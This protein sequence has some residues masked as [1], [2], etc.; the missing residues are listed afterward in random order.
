MA[1]ALAVSEASTEYYVGRK[2]T[3]ADYKSWELKPGE[4]F[5]LIHG[6]AY[7][8]SAPT[9]SHQRISMLLSGEFYAF[10]KDK[11]CEAFAAPVDVRL[12]YE[13]DGSDD[14][15]VQPDLVVVCDP[16]KLGEEGVRGA[17]DVAVEIL[18]PSNTAVEMERKQKSVQSAALPGLAIP[19]SAVF[20]V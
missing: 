9:I 5:E 15:V 2:Y 17:S 7:A 14:T 12:F 3:Y 4:R 1:E 20:P 6:A 10:L 18:S 11:P 13:E 8:M 16:K 19:L